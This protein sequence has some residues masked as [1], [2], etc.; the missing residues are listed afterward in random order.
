MCIKVIKVRCRRVKLFNNIIMRQ[1]GRVGGAG[2]AWRLLGL[3]CG[4]VGNSTPLGT[5]HSA[6]WAC[7]LLSV[8]LFSF[9]SLTVH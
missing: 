3:T 1:M 6:H 9:F 4:Q 2:A 7:F 5:Q 8:Y